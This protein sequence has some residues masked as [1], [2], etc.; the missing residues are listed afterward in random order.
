MDLTGIPAYL[1][2][3][4]DLWPELDNTTKTPAMMERL[5]EAGARGVSNAQGFY[6]YTQESAEHWEKS[7]I[8][9]SYD[10]RKLAEKYSTHL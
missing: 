3:M 5:V 7:F 1:T 4:K 8:E 2:V 10:I 6:P 9:F